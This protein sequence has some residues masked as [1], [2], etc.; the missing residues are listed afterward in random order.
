[1][2]GASGTGAM[3]APL[4]GIAV[5][6]GI[7]LVT[8]IRELRGERLAMPFARAPCIG[9]ST[10]FKT[11]ATQADVNLYLAFLCLS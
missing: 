11:I 2:I 10:V 6:N 8:Y 7:V 3:T 5:L 4:F 9:H 1:M